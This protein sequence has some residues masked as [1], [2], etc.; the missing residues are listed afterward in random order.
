MKID[1]Q[2]VQQSC[3]P[4]FAYL[5][6]PI[7][8]TLVNKRCNVLALIRSLVLNR[9]LIKKN[10]IFLINKEIQM[11]AVVKSYMRKGFL[12]YEEMRKYLP[13]MRRPLV[14]YDFVTAPF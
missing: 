3:I 10:E 5:C 8:Y 2:S 9:T 4:R 12:I 1:Q 14:I 6:T 7:P 11:G 13:I